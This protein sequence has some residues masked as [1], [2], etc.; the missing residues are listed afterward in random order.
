MTVQIDGSWKELDLSDI[1]H[2]AANEIFAREMG[3]VMENV[4]DINTLAKFKR[5]ITLEFE[6]VPDEE[7]S[8]GSLNITAKAVLA[9]LKS[10]A[11]NVAFQKDSYGKLRA[12]ESTMTMTPFTFENVEDI[13]QANKGN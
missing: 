9:P 7:R 2:G 11:S 4:K 6:I 13:N 5:K 3:R 8:I 1:N 12:Y 10:I